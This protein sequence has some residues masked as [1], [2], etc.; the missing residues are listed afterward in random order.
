MEGLNVAEA[1]L[2]VYARPSKS[3]QIRR[4]VLHQ[5]S[6]LLFTSVIPPSDL[7]LCSIVPFNGC[8]QR[9][10]EIFDGVILAYEVNIPSKRAK[11]ISGLIPYI[12]VKIKENLLLF[13]PKPSMLLGVLSLVV[14]HAI[15][16]MLF[17]YEF[18]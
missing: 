2:V 13:S 12:G 4:A 1:D 11:I 18:F 3:N 5:L 8:L 15:L 6:S 17:Y 14:D 10:D 7:I 16:R 9:H